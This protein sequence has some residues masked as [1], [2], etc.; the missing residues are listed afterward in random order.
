MVLI[1]AWQ[2]NSDLSENS[3]LR[4]DRVCNQLESISACDFLVLPELW[5]EGA[6]NLG[7]IKD[8]TQNFELNK[9]FQLAALKQMWIWTGTFLTDDDTKV[10]N[11]GFLI[12]P[13]GELVLHYDKNKI[14]TI[15]G[16]EGK[17]V[18][19]GVEI[20]LVKINNFRT[21]FLTCFDLRFSDI[22]E[23]LASHG[24]ELIVI[25]A[26]WPLSRIDHWKILLAARAVECQSF[27]LGCNGEGIQMQETLGGQTSLFDPNG[28]KV[29]EVAGSTIE[30]RLYEIDMEILTESRTRFPFQQFRRTDRGDKNFLRVREY[31]T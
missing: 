28:V 7:D 10:K 13:N 16:N 31:K 5:A 17:F 18:S 29:Q 15:S 25:S 2:I 14:F 27:V 24:V 11:R 20:P 22:F 19:S 21:A 30:K 4:F 26:A 8:Q 6:F 3:H 1:Q 23:E 12:N 9:L